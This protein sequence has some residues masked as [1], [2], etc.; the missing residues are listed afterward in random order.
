MSEGVTFSVNVD[1][2]AA[3]M[4]LTTLMT[5]TD[6]AV[7][8]MVVARQ[9]IIRGVREG[10]YMVSSLIGSY[11][12][13][14]S[15]IGGTIDPIFDAMLTMLSATVSMMLA[16]AAAYTSTIAMAP[17][18]AV[19]AGIAIGLSILSYANLIASQAQIIA[20]LANLEAQMPKPVRGVA[21]G[22]GF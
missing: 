11:R 14:I 19:V 10:L 3:Q 17:L 15:L 2:A 22:V 20:T 8:K 12:Q 1:T 13:A 21:F 7:R 18:G 4:E 5:M 6:E 9:K 16:I